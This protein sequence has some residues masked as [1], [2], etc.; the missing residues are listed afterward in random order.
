VVIEDMLYVYSLDDDRFQTS[1]I[2]SHP[3]YVTEIRESILRALMGGE[4]KC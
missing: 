3:S 4:W 2:S 1:M